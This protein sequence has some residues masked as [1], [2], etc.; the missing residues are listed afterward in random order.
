MRYI[1]YFLLVIFS[2]CPPAF[3]QTMSAQV[4]SSQRG[5]ENFVQS[6]AS[7]VLQV[8]RDQ[9]L[10]LQEKKKNFQGEDRQTGQCAGDNTLCS[11]ALCAGGFP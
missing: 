9:A 6:E 2:V 1:S 8:L 11:W 3:A 7:Q 10:P 5:A 4:S